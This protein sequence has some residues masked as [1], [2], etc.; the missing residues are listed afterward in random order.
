MGRIW[1]IR[2]S[3]PADC[4]L[5]LDVAAVQRWAADV[6]PVA[7][8]YVVPV[9]D[10]R[11]L[12]AVRPRPRRGM[13]CRHTQP[14]ERWPPRSSDSVPGVLVYLGKGMSERSRL[15]HRFTDNRTI[16]GQARQRWCG[17]AG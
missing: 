12:L 9:L 4:R 3:R 13:K 7:Y 17:R 15:G 14:S 11:S 2:L 6:R 10:L 5:C 1:H 16:S 8:A